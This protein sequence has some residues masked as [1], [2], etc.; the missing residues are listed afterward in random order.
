MLHRD[1]FSSDGFKI[2]VDC[3]AT[4]QTEFPLFF[5]LLRLQKKRFIY[6]YVSFFSM[7]GLVFCEGPDVSIERT[8]F[9]L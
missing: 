9:L 3:D 5:S 6:F 7:Y 1:Y 8:K 4:Y 2:G